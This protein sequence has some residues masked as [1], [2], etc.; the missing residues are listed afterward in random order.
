MG[1]DRTLRIHLAAGFAGARMAFLQSRDHRSDEGEVEVVAVLRR[2]G[3]RMGG[4]AEGSPPC[5]V[6]DRSHHDRNSPVVW[7]EGNAHDSAV[8]DCNHAEALVYRIHPRE[9]TLY[10][11]ASGIGMGR[12][13]G[14]FLLRVGPGGNE[15]E[16]KIKLRKIQ[17]TSATQVT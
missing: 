16:C 5:V 1:V 13:E 8:G 9:D 4:A 6:V 10:E 7:L 15:K 14:L 11:Q 17:H 12:D 2:K 3:H